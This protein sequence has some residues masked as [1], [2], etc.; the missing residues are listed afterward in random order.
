MKAN[1]S[2]LVKPLNSFEDIFELSE[3]DDEYTILNNLELIPQFRRCPMFCIKS[4]D[5]ARA[6]LVIKVVYH[7]MNQVTKHNAES[8]N[9]SWFWYCTECFRSF[10]SQDITR[11]EHE[12]RLDLGKEIVQI[13]EETHPA[14]Y[15]LL[16][17]LGR[18]KV[19]RLR[20]GVNHLPGDSKISY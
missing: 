2:L 11:A 20:G 18:K 6:R 8:E 15:N 4:R 1:R 10:I 19:A 17:Q 13:S 16:R 3:F 9:S 14:E 5:P 7:F 12:L